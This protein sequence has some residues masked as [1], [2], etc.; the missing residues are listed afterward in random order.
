MYVHVIDRLAAVQSIVD[1][2]NKVNYIWLRVSSFKRCNIMWT[3][4]RIILIV[5]RYQCS[6]GGTTKTNQSY[7]LSHSHEGATSNKTNQMHVL[8]H[9][10]EG[11]TNNKTNT[12]Y[13]LSHSH[14]VAT[15]NKTNQMYVLRHSHE[16]ATS[17]KTN[18]SCATTFA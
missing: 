5:Y 10:H 9:S 15:K 14:E 17:N 18:Q 11:A 12:S 8:P 16:G 1:N 4:I 2:C 6:P 3:I 7:M 13:V